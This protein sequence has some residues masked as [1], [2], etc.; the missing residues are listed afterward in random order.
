MHV[1]RCALDVPLRERA[2]LVRLLSADERRRAGRFRFDDD[3]DRFV[4]SRARLRLV[5]AGAGAGPADRLRFATGRHGKPSLPAHPALQ[6]NLSHAGDVALVAVAE[7]AAVGVDVEPLQ[8]GRDLDEVARRFFSAAERAALARLADAARAP[9]ALRC[10]CRKEAYVKARGDGL[11]R[12]LDAFD[13]ATD[14][15]VA[16]RGTSLLLATRPDAEDAGR[17]DLRDVDVGP[18]HAAA[19]AARG[20]IDRVVLIT[21]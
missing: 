16:G 5:L 17:W 2:A 8:R 6:F 18:E 10:W 4:V 9:A 19:V 1:Y 21:V 7:R 14:A 11:A 12:G 15:A 13:V 20:R 3:R